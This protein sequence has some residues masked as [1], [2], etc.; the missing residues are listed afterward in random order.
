MQPR[1]IDAFRLLVYC[2]CTD[3]TY[4]TVFGWAPDMP[5]LPLEGMFAS[6]ATPKGLLVSA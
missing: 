6:D 1:I 5:T 2:D 3:L 4:R